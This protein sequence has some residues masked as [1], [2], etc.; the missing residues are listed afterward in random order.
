MKISFDFSEVSIAEIKK[1]FHLDELCPA[2]T[3]QKENIALSIKMLYFYCD[4]LRADYP[5]DIEATLCREIVILSYSIIDGLVACLGFKMQERCLGCKSHCQHYSVK[6]YEGESI[7]KNENDSFKNADV[8]LKKCGV[9]SLTPGALLFY[10]QYRDRRNNV[11]LSKNCEVITKD[12]CFN[13][14][15]CNRAVNFLN[16]FVDMLYLNQREFV[17]NNK[18]IDNT[19]R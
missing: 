12:P 2:D 3:A 10:T 6:M 7:R 14:K 11:H 16:E 5:R 4:M 9:I 15:H 19:R 8:Y 18:C 17:R 1:H 13:R